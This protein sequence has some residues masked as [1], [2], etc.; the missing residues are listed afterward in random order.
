[1]TENRNFRALLHFIA[2][3]SSVNTRNGLEFTFIWNAS[4]QQIENITNLVVLFHEVVQ[5]LKCITRWKLGH[6]EREERI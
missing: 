1:M 5:K 6:L 3:L 4:V 2:Y